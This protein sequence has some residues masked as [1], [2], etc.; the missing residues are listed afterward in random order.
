VTA[1]GILHE[2]GTSLSCCPKAALSR[3][4]PDRLR[5]VEARAPLTCIYC[6]DASPTGVE[7]IWIAKASLALDADTLGDRELKSS[8]VT[9]IGP[10]AETSTTVG[11]AP[12][13]CWEC[14]RPDTPDQSSAA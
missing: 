14:E 5:P 2:V 4:E 3:G 13:D 6:G 11:V 9:Q 8:E 1:K 12:S 10:A 7:M